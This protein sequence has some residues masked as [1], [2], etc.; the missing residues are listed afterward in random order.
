MGKFI[1]ISM[2]KRRAEN[3]PE[4]PGLPLID[5]WPESKLKLDSEISPSRNIKDE[6]KIPHGLLFKREKSIAPL[7]LRPEI[8]KRIDLR[9]MVI[10]KYWPWMSQ[11][12]LV[13]Q[14]DIRNKHRINNQS[15]S[16]KC[17][18]DRGKEWPYTF[19]TWMEVLT[20][21]LLISSLK[22]WCYRIQKVLQ[23]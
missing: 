22:C 7:P 19:S 16:V 11:Q 8:L 20:L 9:H 3:Y 14:C 10:E 4:L 18:N 1:D 13:E 12:D 5:G 23:L 2:L 6:N 17:W 21:H 15:Y